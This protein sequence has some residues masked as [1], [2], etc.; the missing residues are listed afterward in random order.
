MNIDQEYHDGVT[1]VIPHESL[2]GEDAEQ[3]G[4]ALTTVLAEDPRDVIVD[5]TNIAQIDS[6]GLE[7]LVD[8]TEQLIRS[9]RVLKLTAADQTLREILE[10]TEIASLFE[11]ADSV[12]FAD[13]GI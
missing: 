5:A 11:Y 10:L 13:E 7:M 6:K 3:F 4:Q 2:V 1:V 8:A 9:G 12:D